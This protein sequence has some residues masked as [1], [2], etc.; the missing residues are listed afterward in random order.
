MIPTT[1]QPEPPEFDEQIRQPG[2][3]AIAELLGLLG[4]APRPGRPR[5]SVGRGALRVTHLSAYW[6]ECLPALRERYR[7]LCAYL[8]V[9]IPP[10]TGAAT[11][12]HVQ[13]KNGCIQRAREATDDEAAAEL[14]R[15][16]YEWDNYRL[17]SA[18]MNARKGEADDVLDPAQIGEGW[19]ALNLADLSIRPGEGLT[20]EQRQQ[21]LATIKR[22][23]LNDAECRGAREMYLQSF[24]DGDV[25]FRFFEQMSPFV[26]TE[27]RRQELLSPATA[28][29]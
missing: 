12:D 19:F 27:Y 25:S 9:F 18:T 4:L 11:V 26:A 20:A 8:A 23:Q 5:Q 22:L 15:P 7:H 28:E 2:Q 21:V 16:V 6:T 1:V 13:S 17:V 10:V 3:R 24:I 29:E 14:L